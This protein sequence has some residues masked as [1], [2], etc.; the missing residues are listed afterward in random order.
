MVR[1]AAGIVAALAGLVTGLVGCSGLLVPFALDPTVRVGQWTVW[2]AGV[3]AVTC[4]GVATLAINNM[5]RK[6]PAGDLTVR[7]RPVC[8]PAPDWA[9]ATECWQAYVPVVGGG[10]VCMVIALRT[11]GHYGQIAGDYPGEI[12][13]PDDPIACPP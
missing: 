12:R 8:P 3:A 7:Q 11:D 9:D 4:E 2:C 1:R 10:A 5:G 13:L 6:R